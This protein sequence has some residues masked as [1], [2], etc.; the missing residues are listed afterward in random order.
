MS[1]TDTQ[2]RVL[3]SLDVAGEPLF[4]GTLAA[5]TGLNFNS[6]VFSRLKQLGLIEGHPYRL[7]DAGRVAVSSPIRETG[8]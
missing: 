2:R 3:Q 5:R 7:T 4:N 6:K 8:K 1:L